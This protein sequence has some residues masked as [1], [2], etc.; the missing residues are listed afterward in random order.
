M[1][2][3]EKQPIIEIFFKDIAIPVPKVEELIEGIVI[4]VGAKKNAL[5]VDLPPYRTGIIRGK[6][7]T[8]IRDTIKV[9]RP[10]DKITA[11][12]ID[13]ENEEGYVELSLQEARQEIVWRELE[14]LQKN[15]S[16]ITLPVLD[17]NKGGLIM[18]W[19][20]IQGFL[21]TSQLK[22]AHYPRIDDGDKDKILEEL[23]KLLGEKISVTVISVNQK[24]NKLIFSE[25]GTKSE[26]IKEM[27]SKYNIGDVVEGE[28]TGV[29]DFGIFLKIQDGLEGLVHISE[30][31]WSLV[32]NP[33]VLF[34]IGDHVK[35]K[36]IT[37]ADGKISLSVKTLKPDPWEGVAEK[38]NK[39]DIV[40][41]VV[42]K[43]NKHGALVSIE[44]GISGLVHISGFSSEEVMRKKLELGKSYTFQITLFEPKEHKLTLNYLEENETIGNLTPPLATLV[45][46]TDTEIP[47]AD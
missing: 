11:K 25:K 13:T 43:F 7:F 41:G 31:D 35:A 36:I 20:S 8:N 5:F 39:G 12:I 16:I 45:M 2:V 26:E 3:M 10:G 9:L 14:E 24:E 23:K 19:K 28:V 15:S 18:E 46:S 6:E 17:V 37:I 29:V 47:K 27:I 1:L 30:L 44:E 42:I 32:E 34:K 4:G 21:P 40:T 38:Y 22:T 33:G